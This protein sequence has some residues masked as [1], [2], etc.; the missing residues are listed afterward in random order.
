VRKKKLLLSAVVELPAG[1][2]MDLYLFCFSLGFIGLI[3]IAILGHSHGFVRHFGHHS[4]A[5]AHSHGNPTGNGHGQRSQVMMRH[6]SVLQSWLSPRMFFSLLFAFGAAGTLLRNLLPSVVVL[7]LA[8]VAAWAF[9][10]W[11]VQPIWRLLFG[12]ASNPARTLESVLLEEAEAVTNFD[13]RG[14]GLVAVNLDGQVVQILASL[15][16]VE[17]QLGLRVH[18]GD[19][20]SITAVNAGRNSCTVARLPLSADHVAAPLA[21]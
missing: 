5:G 10:R 2:K 9:E 3:A 4:H 11:M 18:A 15:N 21:S 8:L 14:Q 1:E 6:T 16:P 7:V 17:Q 12:F 20:L 19:R 13:R